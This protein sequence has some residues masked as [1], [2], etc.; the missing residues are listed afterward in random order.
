MGFIQQIE[1]IWR[2]VSL[3][4][5]A[6]LIAI[7][8]TFVI[9]GVL[10]TNWARRPDMGVLYSRLLPAEA[11]KVLDLTEEQAEE[12]YKDSDAPFFVFRNIESVNQ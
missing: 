4:Q 5:R 9:V 6:L 11:A 3:V 12:F 7:V 10:L 2:N 8:L 1:A